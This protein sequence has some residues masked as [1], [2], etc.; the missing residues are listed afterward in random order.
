M[1]HGQRQA[2]RFCRRRAGGPSVGRCASPTVTDWAQID[3]ELRK[4]GLEPSLRPTAMPRH[5]GPRQAALGTGTATVKLTAT[6]NTGVAREATL[7]LAG[8]SFSLNQSEDTLAPMGTLTLPSL[9][10]TTAV[11]A[12]VTATDAV[13]VT[14]VCVTTASPCPSTGWVAF[15][16][17]P[18]V[19]LPAGDG[20]KTVYAWFKDARGNVSAAASAPIKLDITAH[21]NGAVTG[22]A[23]AGTIRLSWSGFRDATSGVTRYRVM[24]ATTSTAPAAGCAGTALAETTALTFSVAAAAGQVRSYRVCAVDAAGNSST[25]ATVRVTGR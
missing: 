6:A 25:G 15:G 10:N 22:T 21:V 2:L 12:T 7:S 8:G 1:A 11:V 17:R 9:T 4:R 14:Q 19:V 5:H 16:A 20:T 3:E 24:Q 23:S 13:G 18:T